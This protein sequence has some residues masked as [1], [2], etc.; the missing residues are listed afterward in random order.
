MRVCEEITRF[1]LNNKTKTLKLKRLRHR[2]DTLIKK[3]PVYPKLIRAR[4]SSR[5]VG[6]RIH[7]GELKRKDLK[8]IF[9]ANSQRAKEAA[10]VLEELTKLENSNIALGFKQIRYSIYEIEKSMVKEISCLCRN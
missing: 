5:D 4:K 1:A 3:L 7:S 6:R 2:I 9:L 10:R 8:E